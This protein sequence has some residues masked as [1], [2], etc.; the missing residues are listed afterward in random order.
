MFKELGGVV[1]LIVA[2]SVAGMST[3]QIC[4]CSQLSVS[5]S[6]WPADFYRDARV[7]F[8]F[9]SPFPIRPLRSTCTGTIVHVHCVKLFSDWKHRFT[10]SAIE[11]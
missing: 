11:P 7:V 5:V 2:A 6:V 8:F 9:S 1:K 3:A 10:T 4:V